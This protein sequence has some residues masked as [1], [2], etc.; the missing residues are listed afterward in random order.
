MYDIFPNSEHKNIVIAVTGI[1]TAKPFSTLAMNFIPELQI[2]GNGQCFP[3]Y[4]YE[5]IE[6]HNE[7]DLFDTNN[8]IN[9]TVDKTYARYDAITDEALFLFKKHYTYES[10]NK[11]DI[12]H[13]IYGI[14]HSPE[15]KERFGATLKRILPRIPFAPDFWAFS[16]AGEKLMNLH[17]NYENIAPFS[18]IED[19][20]EKRNPD[21]RVNKMKFGK[22]DGLV[23][24]SIINYNSHITLKGIPL[25]AYDYVVNGK[26][27]IEWVMERYQVSTDKDS[28]ILND[29]NEWSDNPRYI[30]DLLAKVV[31]VSIK[32]LEIINDLPSLFESSNEDEQ[33][34]VKFGTGKSLSEKARHSNLKIVSDNDTPESEKF[35][36]YLPVYSL[37][38]AA[39]GFGKEEYVENSGWAKV[40][41]E[42]KLNK[43]MFIAKVV[44]HSMEPTIPDGSYCIFRTE[45][46]GSRDGK[47]VLVESRQVADQET[48]QKYTVKRYHSEKEQLPDGTWRHKRIELSPDNKE[49]QSIILGN[50][51]EDDFKVIAEFVNVI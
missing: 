40:E 1:G 14:L 32:T 5:K 46:G 17:I 48:N 13:Y 37:E 11:D 26:S 4:Y 47:I 29:P 22:K 12:F 39:S 21:Y 20:S 44:G 49:F 36:H 33:N 43:D 31:N 34:P 51:T 16:K 50:V 38:A 25:E 42:L 19:I 27:A 45:R 6:E 28:G 2:L 41:S 10:I 18:V 15:Y 24:K 3:R 8:V 35:V 30:I 7:D 9:E 23:D